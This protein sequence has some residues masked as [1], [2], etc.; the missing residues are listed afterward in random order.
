MKKERSSIIKE[1]RTLLPYFTRYRRFYAVGVLCLLITS[2]GQLIIP[3][4][5][6]TAVDTIVS[7]S[8]VLET[9]GITMLQLLGVALVIAAARFGWRHFLFGASRR[10]EKELREDL[11]THLLTLSPSFYGQN[12]TGDIMARATNDM[13]SIR[14]AT[15][16]ALVAFIDGLFMTLAILI[17]LFSQNPR[18][19]L[20]TIAPLPL[21]A[22]MVIGV[23]RIIGGLFKKVQEG[24]SM[25]SEQGRES[26]S[27]IGVIKTFVKESYF[28]RRFEEANENYK[29]RNMA[30]IKL[31]G[32]FM[33]IVTFLSGLTTLLL[34]RFGGELVIL[35][36]IS[37]GEFVATLNYLQ[38]LIWPM[39]GVGFTIN[40]LARGA[41]SLGRINQYLS[42]PPEITSPKKP[43][44]TITDRTITIK[45]LTFSYPGTEAEVL[46]N[47]SLE[48]PEGSF[49]GVLGKTGSGKTTLI[50]LFNRMLD[51]PEGTVLM[52]GVDVR[53]YDLHL[54]RSQFGFVPQDTFLFS[55]TVKENLGYALED[56]EDRTLM[57]VA[58]ISTINRDVADFPDRWETEVGERGVTLSGGQK[59]R[60]AISRALAKDPP[61]LVFDDALSAV[62]TESEE[63]ILGELLEYRKGRTNIVVSHR[64]STLMRADKI[65]V[66][67]EGNVVQH[68][69]HECLIEEEGFYREIFNLQKLEEQGVTGPPSKGE[70]ACE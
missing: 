10:I 3:Q 38:M 40:M 69:T 20:I 27:G 18:L 26:I 67:E 59:Q 53:S 37:P 62:D 64:V 7:G 44:E 32:L 39:L 11:F 63:K 21:I 8:F 65:L 31:Y 33:P 4:F 45:G 14:M 22:V 55:A 34:L 68:G 28:L 2:G 5:I 70:G 24:F 47:V 15:G 30:Y 16:M 54:L 23:G 41:A 48:I 57:H 49:V 35:R 29:Q 50:N 52:G 43:V 61:I 66:L 12:S 60:I 58:E 19:A 36:Q 46:K 42:H 56:P 13:R 9:V 51:P 1:Y 25:L 6:R 17:I